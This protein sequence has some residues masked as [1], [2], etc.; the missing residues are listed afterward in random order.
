M[1]TT[2]TKELKRLARSMTKSLKAQG[3]AV[4]NGVILNALAAADGS[5]NW[6]VLVKQP[7]APVASVTAIPPATVWVGMHTHKH[8][9]DV[10]PGLS[11]EAVFARKRA[12]ALENIDREFP[13]HKDEGSLS[14]D[15]KVAYY[16]NA[17]SDGEQEWFE[18]AQHD[19]E[20][21]TVCEDSAKPAGAEPTANP[22]LD[23]EFYLKAAR[24]H[25]EDSEPDHEVGD[26][27][28][29]LRTMWSVLTPAQRLSF[30]KNETVH[31][32]LEG[33]LVEFEADLKQLP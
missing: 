18:I 2:K 10:Y 8:G 9:T 25:G 15:E 5:F 1:T 20:A 4:P 31:T 12:I 13:E 21:T 28:D 16:W 6:H 32:T 14:D 30:A 7:D 19:L 24:T 27:Q 23:V 29:F 17:L 11:L 26:L 33:A 22:L 3:H